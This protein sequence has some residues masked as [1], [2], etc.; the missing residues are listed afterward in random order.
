M[1][2]LGIIFLIVLSAAVMGLMVLG[3]LTFTRLTAP[4]GFSPRRG[5]RS[6]QKNIEGAIARYDEV[7][8]K[9]GRN[10]FFWPW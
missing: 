3:A 2:I 7:Q 1:T 4:R 8:T 9:R 5:R 10:V 6:R